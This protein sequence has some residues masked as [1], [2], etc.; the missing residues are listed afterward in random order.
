MAISTIGASV[1]LA[2]EVPFPNAAYGGRKAGLNFLVHKLALEQ[3]Q[4]RI[5]V[6][7]VHPGGKLRQVSF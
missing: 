6:I 1:T 2:A 7:P 4:D 5:I 3:K